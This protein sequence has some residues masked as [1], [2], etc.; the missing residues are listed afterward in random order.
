MSLASRRQGAYQAFD[1]E[2]GTTVAIAPTSGLRAPCQP[3]PLSVNC[4]SIEVADVPGPPAG[5]VSIHPARAGS[6]RL[7]DSPAQCRVRARRALAPRLLE[8]AQKTA[9]VPRPSQE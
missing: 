3:R 8:D 9:I 5:R 7:S 6:H 4:P 2:R 1:S